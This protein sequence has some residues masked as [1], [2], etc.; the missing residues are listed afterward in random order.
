[1]IDRIVA[2]K[3]RRFD[4][5]HVLL[6]DANVI[7]NTQEYQKLAKELAGLTPLI[8]EYTEYVKISKDV[9]DLDHVLKERTHDKEF[10]VLVEEEKHKLEKAMKE[11]VL[12]LEEM[13]LEKESG[14][15]KDIIME[16]RAGTGGVEASLFAGD[17][18]RMLM[19]EEADVAAAERMAHQD[20]RAGNS[21]VRQQGV[22]LAH[23]LQAA[24]R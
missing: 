9:K 8:N 24:A 6:A 1:M 23:D 11:S 16:I 14:G 3:K 7:V 15:S 10:I 5:L 21:R 19:G 17:L 12:R 18:L 13:V 4:E 20:V 22:Q 2:E